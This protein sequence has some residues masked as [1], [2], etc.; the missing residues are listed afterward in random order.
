M[1]ISMVAYRSFKKHDNFIGRAFYLLKTTPME[2]EERTLTLYSHSGKH[3]RGQVTLELSIRGMKEAAP[4]GL[5]MREH[6]ILQKLIL[7]H[8]SLK[9]L[10][11]N[12]R[13]R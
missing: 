9:V 7:S 3:E 4:V 6:T 5:S 10:A 1:L 11:I 2:G 8:E 12:G 13:H